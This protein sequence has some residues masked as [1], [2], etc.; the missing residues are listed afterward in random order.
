MTVVTAID[1]RAQ[2]VQLSRSGA[3]G[4]RVHA[5]F[6]LAAASV[7][8]AAFWVGLAASIGRG[9]GVNISTPILTLA[10]A[11]IAVFLAVICAPIVLKD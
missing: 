1:V 10:G 9:T 5:L 7:L 11:A 8:P 6:G 4:S 3:Q 2:P